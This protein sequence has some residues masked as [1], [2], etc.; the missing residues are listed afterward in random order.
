MVAIGEI[1]LQIFFVMTWWDFNK[2]V[3]LTEGRAGVANR[4]RAVVRLNFHSS[5]A[6][7]DDLQRIP[8]FAVSTASQNE[9]PM[10]DL[11]RPEPEDIPKV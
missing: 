5:D 4:Q 1:Q 10:G 7:K 8:I 2:L 11:I 6:K 3:D 9:P